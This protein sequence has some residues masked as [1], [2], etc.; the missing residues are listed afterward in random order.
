MVTPPELRQAEKLRRMPLEAALRLP[1]VRAALEEALREERVVCGRCGT[2]WGLPGA[3]VVEGRG[4]GS[5]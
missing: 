4:P 1:G 2:E 3:V 5:G